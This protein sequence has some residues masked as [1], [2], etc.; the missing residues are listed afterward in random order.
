MR[1]TRVL[2]NSPNSVGAYVNML[3]R[4]HAPPS[5]HVHQ[6][7]LINSWAW[8]Q[9]NK[10][11]RNRSFIDPSH[12]IPSYLLT[13]IL[14]AN[15]WMNEKQNNPHPSGLYICSRTKPYLQASQ[16][17]PG[18]ALGGG[19]RGD[20]PGPGKP[21]GPKFLDSQGSSRGYV[22]AP[23][24]HGRVLRS[25]SSEEDGERSVILPTGLE[26][27][28]LFA[29]TYWA[30]FAWSAW[31]PFPLGS[32]KRIHNV[33]IIHARKIWIQTILRLVLLYWS[34]RPKHPSTLVQ[35]LVPLVAL[36]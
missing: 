34:T 19:G 14:H 10:Q 24:E 26:R 8:P 11:N 15:W 27:L 4:A 18:P 5:Y 3:T 7:T 25:C 30:L 32:V 16:F 13:C 31:A 35:P 23:L 1:C 36:C 20:R 17:Q 2:T 28:F 33:K 6:L 29:Y 12:I 22:A 21:G 9:I